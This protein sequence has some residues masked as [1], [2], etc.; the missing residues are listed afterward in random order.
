MGAKRVQIPSE[1]VLG[2]VGF[3]FRARTLDLDDI[4]AIRFC[5]IVPDACSIIFPRTPIRVFLSYASKDRFEALFFVTNDEVFAA[6]TRLYD[7]HEIL[8]AA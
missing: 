4:L 2:G 8:C 3:S 7:V 1:E 5:P 6:K